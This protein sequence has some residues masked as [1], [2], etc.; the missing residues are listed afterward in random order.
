M[1]Y[2]ASVKEEFINAMKINVKEIDSVRICW[3]NGGYH[4]IPRMY[5]HF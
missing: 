1:Y 2:T 4:E 5:C 3:L